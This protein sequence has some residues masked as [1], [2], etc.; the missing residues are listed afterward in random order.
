MNIKADTWTRYLSDISPFY[1]IWQEYKYISARR[2]SY[3]Y[4]SPPQPHQFTIIVRSIPVSS[5]CSI[6][7][8][9]ESFFK[10]L[11]PTEYLSHV[12]VRRTR[13][14]INLLVSTASCLTSLFV[15][16]IC[17]LPVNHIFIL[18]LSHNIIIMK[19]NIL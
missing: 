13:K 17:L 14:I 10:E 3:F 15:H 19:G 5:S 4:S 16:W 1:I 9:V 8:S 6:S 18:Y 11:Y 2:I 12:V 7:E